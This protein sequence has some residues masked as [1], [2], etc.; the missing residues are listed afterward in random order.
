MHLTSKHSKTNK[1]IALLSTPWP[2]Y[3]RPSIQLGTLKAYLR[4]IWPEMPVEAHHVYLKLAESIGYRQYHEISK[5]TWLAETVYATLLYP[6]RLQQIEKLFY[7][8]CG[9]ISDLRAAGL[10]SITVRVKKVSDEFIN[11][12][13]WGD[14]L[15][16][17]FS[18]SLCQLTSALYFIKRIKEKF[19]KLN[20]VIGGSTFSG[21]ATG[22]FFKLFPEVDAVINGEGELPFSQLIA[23]LIKS[24]SLSGMP[25]IQGLSI[26]E[27]AKDHKAPVGFQQIPSLNA[28][29]PPDYDDYFDLLRSF[30]SQNVFFPVLPVETSRGCW[31]RQ[32]GVSD[33]AVRLCVLQP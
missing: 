4:S 26:P 22:D 3:N 9:R 14:Y 1:R 25:P 2:L 31:W 24:P 32:S 21:S 30:D 20:I 15:L 8:E 33:K 13:N 29:P 17:G 27:A 11:S 28:L 10:G 18:V 7:Q 16:A 19:P 6:E 5:R 23:Y 12:R